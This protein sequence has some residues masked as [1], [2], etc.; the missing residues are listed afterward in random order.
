MLSGLAQFQVSRLTGFLRGWRGLGRFWTI[1]GGLFA[2]LLASL[3]LAGPPPAAIGAAPA[4]LIAHRSK[5][6]GP[7][8]PRVALLVGGI[9][10]SLADSVAAIDHLPPAVSFAVMPGSG[11]L[12]RVLPMIRRRGHEYLLSIPMEPRR[13]PLDDPDSA[14]ALMTTLADGENAARLRTILGSVSGYVGVTNVLGP[15]KGESLM[16]APDLF[17]AV[18]KEIAGRGLFFLEAG[19]QPLAAKGRQADAVLDDDPVNSATLDARLDALTHIALDKGAA[20]GIITLPR[21]VTLERAAAW[22]RGL[23]AK[24]V[25]LVPV[26]TLAS[27]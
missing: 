16:S 1:T 25:D 9:G 12:D 26:G 27:F 11:N 21:P 2:A 20:V 3:Q 8:R 13:F 18:Q 23:D 19:T 22:S 10:L 7:V 5:P 4:P 6:T 15:L 17:G 14:T 24:G